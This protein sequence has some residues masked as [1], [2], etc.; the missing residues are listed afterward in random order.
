MAE[1]FDDCINRNIVE[2]KGDSVRLV[3]LVPI[4]RINRNIVECKGGNDT[5][6]FVGDCVLIETLWNVKVYY[7]KLEGGVP[8]INRNIVECRVFHFFCHVSAGNVL[9]ETLWNVKEDITK[10]VLGEFLY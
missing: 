2:C 5:V 4:S 10:T 9:I 3:F 1:R 8:S 7:N 6:M